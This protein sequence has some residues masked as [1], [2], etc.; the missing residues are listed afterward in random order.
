[1]FQLVHEMP[2]EGEPQYVEETGAQPLN[3]VINGFAYSFS[4]K[5]LRMR[6]HEITVQISGATSHLYC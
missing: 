3:L 2:L 1:M 5:L 4:G 6:L